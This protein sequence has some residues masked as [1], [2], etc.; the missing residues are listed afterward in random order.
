MINYIDIKQ[1][2]SP[3]IFDNILK[4]I[5]YIF[6]SKEY[7]T[8][9]IE[10]GRNNIFKYKNMT[11][12][13]TSTK[14]Q[15]KDEMEANVSTINLGDCERLL[16]EAYSISENETLFIKKIDV[17]EEGMRIPKIEFDVYYELNDINLI[18]LNLSYCKHCKI[19]ISVPAYISEKD[20]DKYN[21]SSGY[22]NDICYV[23]TSDSGTDIILN[24]RKNEFIDNNRTVC[25]DSCFFAYMNY[26]NNKA[27]CSCDVVE[28]SSNFEN[29]KINK[30]KL[31]ENFI[32]IKNIAN[33]HLLVCYNV[34]F[35]I[36]GLIHN[37]GSYSIMIIIIAHFFII[38]IYYSKNLYNQ[39]QN[40]IND[41]LFSINM[42][43]NFNI[44]FQEGNNKGEFI[45]SKLINKNSK[46]D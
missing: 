11:V 34:L 37:Y 28:S 12:T 14:N 41:I 9:E 44:L 6:T 1:D 42:I 39:I 30:A 33:I 27:K 46:K 26:T 13:L 18:K 25:Q 15:K 17:I 38:I 20:I 45:K 31:L 4:K 2:S 5:E 7:D 8:S 19:D 36:K 16:K 29:I 21:A 40:K 22:Y 24:D 23:T 35:S 43:E 3:I 32:D 10:N